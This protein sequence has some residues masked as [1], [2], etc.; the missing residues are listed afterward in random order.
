MPQLL[1]ALAVALLPLSLSAQDPPQAKKDGPKIAWETDFDAAL[2]R[3]AAEKKPLFVAFLMDDEPAND[4]MIKDHY[5]DPQLIGVLSHFV[6]LVSCIGTH[7]GPEGCSKFPGLTCEQHQAIEKQARARWLTDDLVCTPQH[8]GCDPTGKLLQRRIY[9][10]SKSALARMLLMTLNDCGINT[11]G[12]TLDFGKDADSPYPESDGI[13]V[14][15][16][17][18]DLEARNLEVR[19]AALRGLGSADDARALPAVLGCCDKKHDAATRL[20]AIGAVGRKGHHRAVGK[21]TGLLADGD[22][23]IVAAVATSLEAIELSSATPS[24]LAALK[25]EKRD[26][27]L[28]GM[29]RAAAKC[30]PDSVELRDWCLKHHKGASQHLLGSVLVAM[31]RLDTDEKVVAATLTH[32]TSKNQSV[33]GLAAWALGNHKHADGRKALLLLQKNEKAPELLRLV[34]AALKHSA[35]EKVDGYDTQYMIFLYGL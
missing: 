22:A 15:G 7:T 8:L 21:L 27:V 24:L 10:L 29:V 31:G 5:T 25:R 11:K 35:G 3:A 1:L 26:R 2:A 34:A 23:Q 13:Q 6:C 20:A 30:Q 32:I 19:E 33:R 18:K 17:L 16:W 4:L 12:F 28:T 14:T 9:A